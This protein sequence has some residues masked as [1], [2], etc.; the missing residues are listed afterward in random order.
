VRLGRRGEH[1]RILL[2]EDDLRLSDVLARA[3]RQEGWTVDTAGD[4]LEGGRLLSTGSG[5]LVILDLGLPGRDG[6]DLLRSL[7]ES[8]STVPVLILTGRDA[9]EQRVAGLD[10]GADDYLVKPFALDELLARA[11]ALL[12]RGSGAEP[13]LRYADLELDPARGTAMRA[14]QR[15]ALRPREYGLL[16][17]FMRN[18][19]RVLTRARIYESVWE[20]R[21]DGLTNVIEVYIRYLRGSLAKHGGPLIHTLRGRGYMLHREDPR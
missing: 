1:V 11:R 5:D 17:F 14:G 4:G 20:A 18:P 9:L 12:R 8:G 13:V 15:L 3:L 19:E 16:E 6:M 21:Y 2:I 10:A 7:R